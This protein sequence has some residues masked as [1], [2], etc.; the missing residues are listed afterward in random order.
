MFTSDIRQHYDWILVSD[1]DEYLMPINWNSTILSSICDIYQPSIVSMA[2]QSMLQTARNRILI[3]FEMLNKS[4]D[5]IMSD[6]KACQLGSSVNIY[7]WNQCHAISAFILPEKIWTNIP[8]SDYNFEFP[9]LRGKFPSIQPD[10]S[11]KYRVTQA[12]EWKS[13]HNTLITPSLEGT[14]TYHYNN[15]LPGGNSIL[16]PRDFHSNSMTLEIAHLKLHC[17]DYALSILLP[18][19][20]LHT[21]NE[22]AVNCKQHRK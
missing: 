5:I 14:T 3:N 22:A 2:L 18:D 21:L 7:K 4:K 10:D 19:Y 8:K 15:P 17:S 11:L 6:D 12:Q 16:A 13:F 20:S 9:S 1:V